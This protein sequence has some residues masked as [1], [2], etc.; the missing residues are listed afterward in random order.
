[1]AQILTNEFIAVVIA[2]ALV[3]YVTF[4]NKTKF[5]RII[6]SVGIIIVGIGFGIFNANDASFIMLSGVV[7][8]IGTFKLIEEVAELVRI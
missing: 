5:Y 4:F 7:I 6:G 2:L 3:L 1:M 8:V